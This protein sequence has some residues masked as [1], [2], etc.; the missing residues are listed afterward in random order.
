M[1]TEQHIDAVISWVDGNDP[2]HR[3]RRAE[4]MSDEGHAVAE[5]LSTGA[6]STRFVDNGEL[7]YTI[8]SIRKFAPWIRTI[9]LITDNQVPDFF[10][11]EELD[12]LGVVIVDHRVIFEGYEWALPT[13]NSRSIETVVWRIPGLSERFVYFNDD[14]ILVSEVSREDFFVDDKLVVRGSWSPIVTYGS[15]RIWVN[16]VMNWAARRFLGITRSM[17]FLM[18]INSALAAGFTDR[19]FRVPHMPHPAFTNMLKKFAVD[20]ADLFEQNIKYPF[21]DMV[22]FSG[23]FLALHLA[24]RHEKAVLKKVRHVM[25]INAEMDI[26]PV[27]ERKIARILRG[28]V[29]FLCVQGL[30]KMNET[31]RA[32]LLATLDRIVLE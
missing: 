26:R 30:E 23:V 4:V 16:N 2:A 25:M 20:N 17:H 13:F 31:V 32:K 29:R 9:Y 28:D 7:R 21:R 1:N 22:Q 12:R 6:D 24:I 14:F 3:R 18:Q 5:P 10:S 27:I 11:A 8:Y 15:F 19:Y